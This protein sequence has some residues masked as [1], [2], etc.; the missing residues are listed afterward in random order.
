MPPRPPGTL[1]SRPAAYAPLA[2]FAAA[3]RPRHEAWRSALGTLA[4]GAL[5]IGAIIGFFMLVEQVRGAFAAMQL[6]NAIAAGSSPAGLI[7]L[8][9]SFAP[10]AIATFAVTRMLHGRSAATLFGPPA[11]ALSDGLR[12]A[13]PLMALW[14]LLLPLSASGPDIGRHLTPLQLLSWLPLALPALLVQT[15]AEELVFRG[16]L[17]QQLAARFRAPLVWMLLPAALFG[18]LHYSPATFGP[19]A[20]WMALWAA[21]FGLLAADLTARTGSLGA[22]I[23][24]HFATN[25]S[26]MFLVGLYGNLDGLALYNLV[27]NSRDP[28]Q[29]LPWLALDAAAMGVSWL[30]ARLML[31]V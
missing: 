26:A 9:Y 12:V 14:L 7:G 24:F 11:Q 19:N 10:M 20:P 31:R 22:A 3:A 4:I 27:I 8:L 2:A 18:W 15:G 5:Y 21:G 1:L 30:V 23:G 16:Y 29:L 13:L 25:F 17:T 28:A 6:S